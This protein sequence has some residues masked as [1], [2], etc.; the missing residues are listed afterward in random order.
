MILSSNSLSG[1]PIKTI[2]HVPVSHPFVERLIGSIRRELFDQVFF[3]DAA[4]LS[5]K[6]NHFKIY[7]NTQR[8]HASL[9]GAT[10][11][12]TAGDKPSDPVGGEFL[13]APESLRILKSDKREKIDQAGCTMRVAFLLFVHLLVNVA[14][15][16]GPGGSK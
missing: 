9:E 13:R 15:L 5:C 2:P 11:A 3:W 6:L 16:F 7:F 14:K 1:R 8:T 12:E 10:P 4:D